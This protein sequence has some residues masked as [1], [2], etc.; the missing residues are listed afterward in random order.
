MKMNM[1]AAEEKAKHTLHAAKERIAIATAMVT[2]VMYT[3]PVYAAEG[4]EIKPE[5]ITEMLNTVINIVFVLTSAC[6]AVYG[7]FQLI[8]ALIHF[9]QASQSNNGEQR[10]E[11]GSGIGNAIIMLFL[12]GAIFMLK[13]P[14]KSLFG[15]G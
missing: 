12:A 7:A 15:I 3:F 4:I 9:V 8:P 5:G 14:V 11:A 13:A 2:C 10:K 6:I 1:M